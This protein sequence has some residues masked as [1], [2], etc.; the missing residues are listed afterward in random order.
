MD[1]LAHGLWTNAA[2]FKKYKTNKKNRYFAILFG[3]LPDIVSFA[4]ATIYLLIAGRNFSPELYASDFWFFRWAENSYNFTHSLII[5]LITLIV[6]TA[7]R[8]GKVYWPLFGWSVHILIDIFTHKDFY[9]TPF[10]Y[11]IS[12]F[13]FSHG[14]QWAEP[15]FMIINYGALAAIY[16]A[17]FLVIRKK[18]V[19]L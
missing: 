18:R 3:I 5:F 12:D 13:K 10:L 17:W 14:I 6:I 15:G 2:F 8:K 4:P 9:E 1:I 7:V 11:P 16:L 19:V